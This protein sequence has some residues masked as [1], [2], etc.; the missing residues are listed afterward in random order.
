MEVKSEEADTKQRNQ[1]AYFRK[2]IRLPFNS[3]LIQANHVINNDL[4]IR[5]E[6]LCFF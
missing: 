1:P 6:F 2:K 3:S 5:E 4:F